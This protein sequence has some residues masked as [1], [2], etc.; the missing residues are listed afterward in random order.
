MKYRVFL[1]K[2]DGMYGSLGRC[3]MAAAVHKL[4]NGRAI[5]TPVCRYID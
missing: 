3:G 2:C 5:R 4:Q 1:I